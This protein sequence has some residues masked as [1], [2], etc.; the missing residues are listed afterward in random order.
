MNASD[1]TF[2]DLRQKN[3]ERQR[4]WQADGKP[5]NLEF[6][7]LELGGEVGELQNACKK[8]IRE[9]DGHKGSRATF[10][11]MEAEAAD[12]AIALDLFCNNA[13]IDLAQAIKRKFNAT[14]RK[15][16]FKTV[17]E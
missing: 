16:G 6:R 13:K 7:A 14:S 8:I 17:I 10:G 2:A 11:D 5:F 1:F 15:H 12:V 3:I 4:E 9:R